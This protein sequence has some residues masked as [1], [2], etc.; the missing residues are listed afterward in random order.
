MTLRVMDLQGRLVQQQVDASGTGR[1]T[2]ERRGMAAGAY[3]YQLS[4]AVNG[5]GKMH[6]E[7]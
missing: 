3:H 2:I 7:Q 6:V 5:A 1:F 4:G